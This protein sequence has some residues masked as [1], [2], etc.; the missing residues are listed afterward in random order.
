M[1]GFLTENNDLPR[2]LGDLVRYYRTDGRDRLL[3]LRG[4]KANRNTILF[5]GMGTSEFTPLFIQWRLRR[6]GISCATV[7]TGEWLH[8]GD[9][10]DKDDLVVLTSQSGESVELKRL[11]DRQMANV[12]YVAITNFPESSLARGSALVLPLR[13]G[14]EESITTKT[15]TNTLGILHLMTAVLC[16]PARLDAELDLLESLSAVMETVD[17]ESIVGAAESLRDVGST[18][19]VGRGSAYISARQSALTFMEGTRSPACAF[20][21]GAFNHGPME[22]VD[23]RMGVV[24]FSPSDS[25]SRLMD[26]LRER[27]SRR[28][29]RTVCL[30]AAGGSS[31]SSGSRITVPRAPEGITWDPFPLLAARSHNLLLHHVARLRGIEA[32]TFRY[33]SK[34]TEVE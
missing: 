3:A 10:S 7:D 15:Y 30:C 18:V 34:V 20:T 17:E 1:N 25:T 5:S 27:A 11:V 8:F 24:V 16:D 32:G 21:G 9:P 6:C 31:D 19:F 23:G 33:G 12:P 22:A 28:G 4:L 2:A 14:P 29:A 26:G 13:A